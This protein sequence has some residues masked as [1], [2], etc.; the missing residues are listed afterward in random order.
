[1]PLLPKGVPGGTKDYQ[2]SLHV[3]DIISMW[4]SGDP[5]GHVAV[6]KQVDV[7][8]GANGKYTGTI[9]IVNENAQGGVTTLTVSTN[10]MWYRHE[11]TTFQWLTGLP[12]S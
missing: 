9:K 3:G 12:T 5:T 10:V 7:T 4:S 2:P 6:V 1:V 11:F 8:K